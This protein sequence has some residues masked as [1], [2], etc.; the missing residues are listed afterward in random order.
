MA[1]EQGV[2]RA[3]LESARSALVDARRG[4]GPVSVA[5]ALTAV[6]LLELEL[7]ESHPKYNPSKGD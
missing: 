2:I 3:E 5:E 6:E 4:H 1:R 7:N